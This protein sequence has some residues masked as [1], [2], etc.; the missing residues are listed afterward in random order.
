M[1]QWVLLILGCL[2]LQ[3][4]GLAKESTPSTGAGPAT[5]SAA[6]LHAATPDSGVLPSKFTDPKTLA[7]EESSGEIARLAARMIERSH[8]LRREFD[9]RVSERFFERYLESLDPQRMYFT[10]SDYEEFAAYRH[11]LDDLTLRRGDTRPAY[12]IFNRYLQRIDQQYALVQGIL[13]TEKF[14]FDA[15]DRMLLNRKDS[16]RPKDLSELQAIWKD[17]LRFEY[18]SEKLNRDFTTLAT[19]VWTQM[20]TPPEP[21]SDGGGVTNAAPATPSAK[22]A[23]QAKPATRPILA[24]GKKVA[25]LY[26]TGLED[27]LHSHLTTNRS[28]LVAKMAESGKFKGPAD[29]R[30]YFEANLQGDRHEEILKTL[31]RRYNRVMRNLKQFEPKEVLQWYLDALAHSYDPHTNYFGPREE[32]AFSMS[33]TLSFVGIG[34]VLTSEDGYATITEIKPGSPAEKSK[35]L[36]A[37]DKIVAVAQDRQPPVDVIDEK[38][39]KVVEQIRGPKG[40]KVTLTYIPSGSDLS[41]RKTITIVRDTIPLEE[42]EAKAKLVLLPNGAGKT[43]RIGIIDLPAFYSGAIGGN[44]ATKSPTADVAKLLRKLMAEHVDGVVLDL[45]RNGGGS[46][47]ECVSLTGLFI[48]TG[49][50][51]QVVNSLGHQR[52][53]EDEDSVVLYDG[54]LVVLTSRLS[55]SASEI[56]A[57]ALQDYGRAVVV[58]DSSTHGKGTV[59]N[60]QSLEPFYRGAGK[61]GQVKVTISKFFR[62][63][64]SSTQL[65]G[66]VPDVVLPSINNFADIGES[67]LSNAL[68]W[69]TIPAVRFDKLDR[70]TRAL[71]ELQRR[72]ADRVS[73]D[74]DYAYIGEDIERYR[75]Q[76]A[77]RTVSLNE[78]QRRQELDADR[79]RAALRKAEIKGR[80]ESEPLTYEIN[81]KNA[82][83]PGLPEP[84]ASK[85]VVAAT[86]RDARTLKSGSSKDSAAE[87]RR[88]REANGEDAADEEEE[89]VAADVNLREAERVLLDLLELSASRAGSTGVTAGVQQGR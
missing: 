43:N 51:V 10:Q 37:G 26:L 79:N 34:A 50:V 69:N 32:E 55:A 29:L 76:L 44:G 74:R 18:L 24:G 87:R 75:K 73:K 59:Q 20:T 31:T 84:K 16:P 17:R 5:N 81:L 78:K 7:P 11:L 21:E 66:V 58:G 68:P 64:G 83:Q 27:R 19:N 85:P 35:S 89:G 63:S 52:I 71:P 48:K 88:Q 42:Q 33:M 45:R 49:P 8:F 1:N 23:K 15:D 56:L 65:K 57:G 41:T 4:G 80:N 39:Q 82:S 2:W 13:K 77:D 14:G 22:P 60:L 3:V 61:P 70:V 62:P 28:T 36:K 54:P 46:L 67:A 47:E 30:N 53:L 9:D 40:S 86:A 25:D 12:E 72:S 6:A 38:L